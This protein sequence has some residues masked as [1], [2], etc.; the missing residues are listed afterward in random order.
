MEV[1][2]QCVLMLRYGDIPGAQRASL[3]C[4]QTQSGLTMSFQAD[5]WW[6]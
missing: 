5:G 6:S 1:D 2:C 3:A 4:T